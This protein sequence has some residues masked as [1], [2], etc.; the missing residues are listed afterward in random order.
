MEVNV[1]I[2]V[3]GKDVMP[4]SLGLWTG[5]A[6]GNCWWQQCNYGTASIDVMVCLNRSSVAYLMNSFC[7]VTRTSGPLPRRPMTRS[8]HA[9]EE[10]VAVDEKVYRRCEEVEKRRDTVSHPRSESISYSRARSQRCSAR[11][12]PALNAKPGLPG[13]L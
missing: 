7:L 9:S 2:R 1:R 11:P 8:L 13:T 6:E 10:R 4:D 5:D 12:R 3:E